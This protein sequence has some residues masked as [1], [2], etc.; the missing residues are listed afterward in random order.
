[1][2]N[3][4]FHCVCPSAKCYIGHTTYWLEYSWIYSNFQHIKTENMGFFKFCIQNSWNQLS[5]TI[6][7]SNQVFCSIWH[8]LSQ[9]D[10]EEN[11]FTEDWVTYAS[12]IVICILLVTVL[13]CCSQLQGRKL[14]SGDSSPQWLHSHLPRPPNDIPW[15]SVTSRD[16]QWALGLISQKKTQLPSSDDWIFFPLF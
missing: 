12:S 2:Y 15:P 7:H 8:Y 10:S 6:M 1:M 3:H 14:S 9:Q 13:H 4:R 11:F 5:V 16:T